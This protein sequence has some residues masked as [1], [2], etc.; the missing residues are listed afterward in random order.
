MKNVITK[1]HDTINQTIEQYSD[2]IYKVALS[3]TKDKVTAE[4]ILQDVLIKYMTDST[5]FNGDEHKKAWLIRVTINECKKFY[6]SIWNLRKIPLEDVYP[7][8]EPEKHEVFYAVMELPPKYRLIIHLH[9]YE[10]LSINEI[11]NVL[12]INENTIRSRL[13]RG[14]KILKNILEVEYEYGSI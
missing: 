13:F 8:N 11:S 14:R 12:N 2:T 5:E 9:Y 7:F 10:D 3:Y 4:D 1:T 6:R